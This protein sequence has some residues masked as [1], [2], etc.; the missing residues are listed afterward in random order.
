MK[1]SGCFKQEG[2]LGF[3]DVLAVDVPEE[4]RDVRRALFLEGGR[5]FHRGGTLAPCEC[6]AASVPF[7]IYGDVRVPKSISENFRRGTQKTPADDG[8]RVVV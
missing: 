6:D 5:G 2:A 3:F 1:F 4:Y 8:R 7:I